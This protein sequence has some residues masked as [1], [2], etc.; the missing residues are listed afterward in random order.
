MY[1]KTDNNSS[2]RYYLKK[3]EKEKQ[4]KATKKTLERHQNLSKEETENSA[5]TFAKI[6]KIFPIMK[7]KGWL[8]TERLF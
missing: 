8:S 6:I 5:N 2:A 3:E 1:I 4:E 7:S